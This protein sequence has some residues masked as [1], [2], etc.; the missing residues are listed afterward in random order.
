MLRGSR[1]QLGDKLRTC[2][3]K[4]TQS[5]NLACVACFAVTARMDAMLSVERTER[6]QSK[7]N[8][9]KTCTVPA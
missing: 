1:R 7:L 8:I 3:G 6:S 2:H 9:L 4:V 5:W